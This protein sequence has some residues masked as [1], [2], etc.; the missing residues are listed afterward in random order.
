MGRLLTTAHRHHLPSPVLPIIDPLATIGLVDAVAA[1]ARGGAGWVE[2]RDKKA[3]DRRAHE[4]AVALVAACRELGVRLLINDR[5]DVALATGAD[6]VHLG[7]DDLPVAAAR[8][9]LGDRAIIGI[10]VDTV[11]EAMA[12]EALPVDYIAIGPVFGTSSKP[13]AGRV[14]GLDGVRAA[15]IAI[16]KPLVAVGGIDLSNAEDVVAAGCDCVAVLS[17]LFGSRGPEDATRR[18]IEAAEAALERRGD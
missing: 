4:R 8:E 12:A 11:E 18:L 16:S 6:G 14:I 2:Y 7:Q 9:L 3:D 13:D 10:S 15:A 1:V 17:A 5:V